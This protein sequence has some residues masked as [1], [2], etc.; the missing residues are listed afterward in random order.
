MEKPWTEFIRIYAD[1]IPFK[2]QETI[3]KAFYYFLQK[4]TYY[5]NKLMMTKK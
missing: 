1:R 2:T 3:L 5:A 4:E